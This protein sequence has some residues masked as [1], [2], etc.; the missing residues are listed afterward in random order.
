MRNYGIIRSKFIESGAN[1]LNHF[2]VLHL[3]AAANVIGLA[4]PPPGQHGTNRLAVIGNI[5]P[6]TDILSV[7]IHRNRFPTDCVQDD[8]RN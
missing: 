1:S 5:D 7:S 8:K 6:V 2:N 4:R 3:I